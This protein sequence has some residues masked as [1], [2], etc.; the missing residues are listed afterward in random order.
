[1]LSHRIGRRP[2][3]WS[4]LA[5]ALVLNAGPARAQCLISGPTALCDG[6]AA[7]LCGPGGSAELVWMLPDGS[8]SFS[9]CIVAAAPGTYQLWV[10]DP[11]GGMSGPCTH[12]IVAGST[13][14]CSIQGPATACAGSALQLCG[15]SGDL[16]YTWTGPGGF[17]DSSACVNV[18]VAGAY[19]LVVSDRASGCA[20]TAS[21][22][23]VSFETCRQLVNC[24]R[25]A[26]FW[27]QQCDRHDSHHARIT[28]D[29][30]AAIATCVDA[31]SACFTWGGRSSLCSTLSPRPR[32]LRERALRQFAAVVANLCAGDLGV[33]GS[34]GPA[35]ALDPATTL[36]L[37]GAP[38]TVGDWIA[39]ADARL[40]ALD[41]RS[42]RDPKA[43]DAWRSIIRT[44]WAINHGQ[45][46]GP[47]CGAE[48]GGLAAGGRP[49]E[50]DAGETLDQELADDAV[51]ALEIQRPEPNPF[52]ARA[53]IAYTVDVAANEDVEIAV[54]DIAGRLVRQLVHGPLA[55]GSYETS[56]D[57]TSS[58]GVPA[59]TGMYIVHGRAGAHRV[60]MH[61]MLVR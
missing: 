5:L 53:R 1:M 31:H 17:S 8:Q 24:P 54:Y 33:A 55:P 45:G 35:I 12:T 44:A 40:V 60:D 9:Q 15:P 13:P 48:A 19:R 30:L 61:I 23:S 7:Q 16:A 29:A 43:R 46:I 26:H 47:V 57:G 51:A 38:A 2:P 14:A 42:M 6:G 25:T 56:W 37:P 3:S 20:S 21:E 34:S 41:G 28:R 27:E 50:D 36:T 22:Q 49:A 52:S 18:S 4:I 59:H 58:D 11:L 32:R 10:F 39:S